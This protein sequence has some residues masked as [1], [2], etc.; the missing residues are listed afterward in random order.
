[1]EAGDSIDRCWTWLRPAALPE[2]REHRDPAAHGI[3]EADLRRRILLV[4]DDDDRLADVLEP[5][6]SRPQLIRIIRVDGDRDGDAAERVP[7]EGESGHVLADG[8]FALSFERRVDHR[9]LPE[10]RRVVGQDAVASAVDVQILGFIA[11]L[12]ER[13]EP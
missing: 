8:G 6:V 12:R 10:R 7:D 2:L 13:G 11:D 1:V 3:L 5:A 9:E 4:A